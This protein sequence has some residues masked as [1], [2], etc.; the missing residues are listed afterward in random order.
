MSFNGFV[1]EFSNAPVQPAFSSYLS[2]EL[3]ENV[4]LEWPFQNQ[5]TLYPF[6]Q[7]VQINGTDSANLVISL[8]DATVTSV[9]QTV[10]FLNSADQ[11]VIISDFEQNIIV[12]IQPSQDYYLTLS[13]NS[14]PSGIWIEVQLGATTSSATAASLIDTSNDSNGHQNNGGLSAFPTNYIKM[15]QRINLFSGSSYNQASGDRGSLLV[16]TGGNGSYNCLSAASIGNGYNFSIHNASTVSG[17]ITLI[18]NGSDTIDGESTFTIKTNES[19]TFISNGV[20]SFYSL[21]YG[22]Q[23]TNII[24]EADVPLSDAI[25]N[26]IEITL[27]QA[28][29]LILNFTGSSGAPFYPD[30]TI[31]LPS[32]F[33]N[34]YYL[35]NSSTTNDIIVQVG[36]G[37]TSFN[38][39]IP[40]NGD[41][42]IGYTDLSNFY[43][44]PN[45]FDL[46]NL[47]FADGTETNP[48]ISFANDTSTGI[49]RNTVDPEN[50]GALAI[51]QDGTACA[52]FKETRIELSADEVH[53]SEMNVFGSGQYTQEEINIYSIMRAYG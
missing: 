5:N 14:D 16:W 48:S 29:N 24:T 43:N 38:S 32:N 40:K 39:R 23:F 18:P 4:A 15:N 31:S 28:K 51:T 35:Q 50:L 25:S 7:T 36:T 10:C 21:G 1:D 45:I 22:Q 26:I 33:V 37:V 44:I 6:S 19:A 53:S 8:P 13:D 11:N 41:R 3:T 9:G 49:F 52:F 12:T 27:D 47:F 30:I 20:S 2:L 17:V 46:D 34:Q 42:I